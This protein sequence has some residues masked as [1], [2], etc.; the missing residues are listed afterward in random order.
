MLGLNDT[1]RLLAMANSRHLYWHFFR[2]EDDHFLRRALPLE[3]KCQGNEGRL[4]STWK[5]QI[6]EKSLKVGL[7][8]E[9]AL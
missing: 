9:D 4:K 1:I 2:R 7:R 6:E 5:K 8:R 3:V